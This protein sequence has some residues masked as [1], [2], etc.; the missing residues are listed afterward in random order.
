MYG[1]IVRD[2]REAIFCKCWKAHN[3]EFFSLGNS[4]LRKNHISANTPL[5]NFCAGNPQ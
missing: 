1:K 4:A 2:S 5:C 3:G